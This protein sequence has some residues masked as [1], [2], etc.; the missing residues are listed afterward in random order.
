MLLGLV[1]LCTIMNTLHS[2]ACLKIYRDLRFLARPGFTNLLHPGQFYDI[3]DIS[4][5]IYITSDGFM[6]SVLGDT[7]ISGC[8]FYDDS[9]NKSCKNIYFLETKFINTMGFIS[10]GYIY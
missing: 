8:W 1:N 5:K 2:V 4:F 9:S 3:G 7:F 10:K 6:K